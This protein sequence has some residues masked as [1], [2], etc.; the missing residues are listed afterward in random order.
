MF[1]IFGELPGAD[2]QK[3]TIVEEGQLK[4]RDDDILVS[5]FAVSGMDLGI[6]AVVVVDDP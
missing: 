5:A 1:R 6:P 3:G 4:M 2:S